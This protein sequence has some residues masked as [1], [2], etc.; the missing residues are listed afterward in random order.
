MMQCLSVSAWLE[1]HFSAFLVQATLQ[2]TK[3]RLCFCS[4]A[5]IQCCWACFQFKDDDMHKALSHLLFLFTYFHLRSF[6]CFST[7]TRTMHFSFFRRVVQQQWRLFFIQSTFIASNRG[8]IWNNVCLTCYH[9]H[10]LCI[11]IYIHVIYIFT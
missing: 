10:F 3:N 1:L 8:G 11:H 2:F 4:I 6:C 5:I 7:C 9:S